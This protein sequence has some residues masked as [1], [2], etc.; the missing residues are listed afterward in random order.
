M[1]PVDNKKIGIWGFGR[2]GKAVTAFL[3]AHGYQVS[4]LD[5]QFSTDAQ[6][7]LI[8]N[9]IPFFYEKNKTKFLDIHDYILPSPGIDLRPYNKKYKDKWI[10]ELDLFQKFFA[11]QIIAITGTVGKTTVTHLLSQLLAKLDVS[12]ATGGNIGTACF[13][14]LEYKKDIALLEV[15]SFQLELCK[16]FAPDLAIWTNFSTN[17]LDR[18]STEQEYFNAKYRIIAHQNRNQKALVPFDLYNQIKKLKPKS[19][20]YFCAQ[21]KPHNFDHI[22][23]TDTLFYSEKDYI[24]MY[25]N[26]I[27]K[28]IGSID[29]L[30]PITFAQNWLIICAALYLI[31]QPLNKLTTVT[32]SLSLPEHRLELIQKNNIY[33][34]ND[35]KSTTPTSTLAAIKKLNG[36]PLILFLGG[37]GKGIDRTPLIA[38]LQNKVKYIYCFGSEANQLHTLCTQYGIPSHHFATLDDAFNQ[39]VQRLKSGDHVLFSPAGSSFDLFKNYEERGTYFKKLIEVYNVSKQKT[40]NS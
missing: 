34:F 7:W 38:Q 14:L 18:H 30:P 11:K 36:K 31:K 4:V 22:E 24:I 5:K 33:F 20:V 12:V 8:Q 28:I 23:L 40:D 6:T 27:H 35:S 37:L 17:H 1:K 13:N 9:S 29:E 10:A 26:G 32:Q 19:Y 39:C 2:V 15:S 3:H 25:H 21:H 16:T